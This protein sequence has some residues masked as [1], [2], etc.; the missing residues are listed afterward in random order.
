MKAKLIA[1]WFAALGIILIS[2]CT[3]SKGQQGEYLYNVYCA[4]CHMEDGNGL[5]RLYPPLNQADFLAENQEHIP[6]IIRHGIEGKIIVNGVEF[7][8]P[9]AG[10]EDLNDV[11]INNIINYINQAWDNDIPTVNF[12]TTEERLQQCP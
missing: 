12:K 8:E 5:E 4:P 1:I 11:E 6:C 10:I 2:N 7:N 3:S 9:M